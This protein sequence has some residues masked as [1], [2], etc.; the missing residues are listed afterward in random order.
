MKHD[1]I[2]REPDVRKITGLSTS[3]IRRKEKT[4][5]FP[6]RLRLSENAIGWRESAIYEWLENLP[7]GRPIE[8]RGKKGGH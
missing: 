8:S 7:Q 2:L 4:G 6:L 1:K 3:T 5:K